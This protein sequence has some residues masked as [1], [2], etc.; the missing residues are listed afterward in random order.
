MVQY[1]NDEKSI[2]R[3]V[4]CA[5]REGREITPGTARAIASQYNDGGDTSIYSFVST[6]AMVTTEAFVTDALMYAFKRG[7][8]Q[9]TLDAD[10]R[11][12][13]ALESY[14]NERENYDD[15]DRVPGW[16]EMWVAR[17][18]D[19]PHES[20]RLP[21]CPACQWECFCSELDGETKC[22]HCDSNSVGD[23]GTGH[24]AYEFRSG[25]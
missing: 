7:V 20:G 22:V 12:L 1:E 25:A 19:Y 17:H 15:L 18:A 14:L 16:S 13:N 6:G 11:A 21:D 24:G 5:E 2:A 23:A 10:E 4:K 8:G 9:A 3:E